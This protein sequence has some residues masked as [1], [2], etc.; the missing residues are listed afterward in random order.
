MR[1][2]VESF[3]VGLS[4]PITPHKWKVQNVLKIHI[5]IGITYG[6]K[7]GYGKYVYFQMGVIKIKFGIPYA[8]HFDKYLD[9]LWGDVG[10]YFYITC[11]LHHHHRDQ[12]NVIM[13]HMDTRN[14]SQSIGVSAREFSSQFAGFGLF[15]SFNLSQKIRSL[16]ILYLYILWWW[17]VLL[18]MFVMCFALGIGM[19]LEDLWLFQFLVNIA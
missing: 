19:K 9:A 13:T 12:C 2:Y 11:H 15:Q 18:E 10:N 3:V 5:W 6:G 16:F 17:W 14:L 7:S 4:F 1:T 8:S